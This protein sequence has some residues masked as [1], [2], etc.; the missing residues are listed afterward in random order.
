VVIARAARPFHKRAA[1]W[2]ARSRLVA[3]QKNR[4]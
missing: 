4:Y 1:G 3:E 2:V